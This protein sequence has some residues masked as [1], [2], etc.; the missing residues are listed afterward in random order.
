MT[1]LALLTLLGFSWQPLHLAGAALDLGGGDADRPGDRQRAARAVRDPPRTRLRRWGMFGTV[2]LLHLR[3]AAGASARTAR[4]RPHL[5]AQARAR[6]DCGAD[7]AHVP[8]L[9]TRWQAPEGG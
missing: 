8:V 7:P 9:V 2:A 6:L 5:P 4:S 3:P 1:A